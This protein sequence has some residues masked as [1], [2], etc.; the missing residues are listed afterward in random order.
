MMRTLGAAVGAV[1]VLL[2]LGIVATRLTWHNP[3]TQ[4]T[5]EVRR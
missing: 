3:T 5:Q 2:F 4:P 1:L